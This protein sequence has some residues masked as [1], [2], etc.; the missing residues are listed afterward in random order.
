[1]I[2]VIFKKNNKPLEVEV[3]GG[4]AQPGSYSIFLWEANENKVVQK[5]KGNFIN[6]ADDRYTLL[7]PSNKNN[8][9]IIDTVV[10]FVI[11]APIKNYYSEIIVYQDGVI[12]GKDFQGGC[13]DEKTISIKSMIKLEMEG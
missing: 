10:T 5:E 1:M 9:R 4:Y 6:T 7:P 13:T 12:I 3:R 8:G 11:T 2:T